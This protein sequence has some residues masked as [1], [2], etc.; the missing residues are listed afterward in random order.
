MGMS[1]VYGPCAYHV[2]HSGLGISALVIHTKYFKL[3]SH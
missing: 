3:T 1:I 2:R